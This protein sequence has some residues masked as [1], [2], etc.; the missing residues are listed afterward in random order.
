MCKLLQMLNYNSSHKFYNAVNLIVNIKNTMLYTIY[1]ILL[2]FVIFFVFNFRYKA[3]KIENIS[4]RLL[5]NRVVKEIKTKNYN[6]AIKTLTVF[7][8]IYYNSSYYSSAL[9]LKAYLY[10][11]DH[12]YKNA[13][14]VINNF[15]YNHPMSQ[16]VC[17]M[18]YIKGMSSYKQIIDINRDQ[19]FTFRARKYFEILIKKYPYSKYSNDLKIKLEYID[20]MLAGKEM[21]IGRFYLGI[22]RPI[23][24][25]NRF[26]IVSEKYQ[27]SIFTPEALYKLI[28]VYH[29]LGIKDQVKIFMLILGFNYPQSIWY[30]KLYYNAI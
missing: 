27:R 2:L 6:N 23:V 7:E 24:A 17:Y 3:F 25:I 8:N 22:N 16:N 29:M 18:Y 26:K 10:Y 30:N 20:N 12:N 4:E 15:L 1:L 5:F 14:T 13:V 11:L 9:I 19:K 21:N 28:E